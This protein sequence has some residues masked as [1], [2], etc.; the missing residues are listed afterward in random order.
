MVFSDERL[1][2]LIA[3]ELKIIDKGVRHFILVLRLII[4]KLY[5]SLHTVLPKCCKSYHEQGIS[6]AALSAAYFWIC[7]KFVLLV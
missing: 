1:L 7:F 6:F 3:G 2:G 4:L 5:N